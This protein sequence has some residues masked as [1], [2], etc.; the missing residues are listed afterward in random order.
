MTSGARERKGA[1]LNGGIT[2]CGNSGKMNGPAKW[3]F[4]ATVAFL[5]L[6]SLLTLGPGIVQGGDC[7]HDPIVGDGGTV[8]FLTGSDPGSGSLTKDYPS[9]SYESIAINPDGG[10]L[11]Q[12]LG[13]WESEQLAYDWKVD[14]LIEVQVPAW[15]NG[16]SAST[17]FTVDVLVDGES[18]GDML[19]AS[20]GMM[21]HYMYWIA[22]DTFT[23]TATAGQ[24]IGVEISVVEN[25]PGGE[26]RWDSEEAIGQVWLKTPSVEVELSDVVTRGKHESSLEAFSYWGTEDIDSLGMLIIDPARMNGGPVWDDI[27]NNATIYDTSDHITVEWDD[28]SNT[29]DG[30]RNAYWTWDLPDDM[31]ENAE[32]VGFASDGGLIPSFKSD[33]VAGSPGSDPDPAPGETSSS[34]DEEFPWTQIILIMA[35]L[36]LGIAAYQKKVMEHD[37]K[38]ILAGAGAITIVGILLM[39]GF[40]NAAFS[41]DKQ[42]APDFSL[43]TLDDETVSLKELDDKVIVISFSG[44]YCSFCEPQMEEMVK[45]HEEFKDNEDVFFL[46]VNIMTGDDDS[47]W[48]EFRDDLG[49][50]WSFAMDNDGMVGKF[51]ISSMPVIIM[52]DKEGDI[53]YT[54]Q[55][56]LLKAGKFKDKINEVEEGKAAGGLTFTGGSL[57]FAFFVGVTAFFAPCAFPLLP[58]FMTYQLGKMEGKGTENE[59][60]EYYGDEEN[61]YEERPTV[62]KPGVMKGLKMGIAAMLGITGVMIIFALLG[63]LLEDAIQQNLKYYTPVLGAVVAILGLIFLLHIPLPTGN[64]G[65]RIRSSGFYSRNIG[66]RVE[67]LLGDDASSGSRHIGVMAYG[68]GYA[69]ASMGCHGPIFIAVLLI[70]LAGGFLLTLEMILLYALGMGICM[71]VVCIL[72]GMAED[73][74]I[75]KLQARL[76]TI[77]KVSG[78]FLILAGLWIFWTGYQ[79]FL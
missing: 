43:Q 16:Y 48:R 32:V 33:L 27:V 19:T 62:R 46:S 28:D 6:A 7:C 50:N 47:A 35:V 79:A 55:D 68:A 76:P 34:S 11:T 71:V 20:D 58:G 23:F 72:V 51:K 67:G 39:A 60:E 53:A 22:N 69:S 75:D 41:T 26:M 38:K 24:R 15:G 57:L 3:V 64:L 21:P 74:A 18:Q 77:N 63:W 56:S 8:L 70:G 61:D 36:G 13:I 45:V 65:E 44:I 14:E 30:H 31:P 59:F 73:A 40:Y 42:P 5:L 52:I 54:N 4:L 25:G 66:P 1:P 2:I 78:F 37:F 29:G 49:A 10:V 17:V 12:N 9:G